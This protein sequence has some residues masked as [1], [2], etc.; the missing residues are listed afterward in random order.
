MNYRITSDLHFW[1]QNILNFE[2]MKRFRGDLYENVEQMNADIIQKFNEGINGKTLTYILGDVCF[3]RGKQVVPRLD[4]ILDQ[5]LGDIVLIKGN[6]DNRE[7]V[8][9]FKDYGHKVYE[10]FE[11]NDFDTKICLSHYPFGAWNKSHFGA[12]M[13]HGHS[14]G[15]YHAPGRILDVG[16]DVHGRVLSLNEAYKMCMDKEIYTADHH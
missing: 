10:Y 12:V 11:I 13:M 2:S 6:H 1:H 14:H 15:S 16:W 4:N 7:A 3:G 9:V 8:A 5:L